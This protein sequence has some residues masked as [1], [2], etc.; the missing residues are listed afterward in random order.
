MESKS[1]KFVFNEYGS[2]REI[3]VHARGIGVLS[4]NYINKGTAFSEK[5]RHELGMEGSLP[6]TVRPLEKQVKNSLEKIFKNTSKQ[7]Q[8]FL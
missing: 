1:Y 5:E 8:H 2:T 3:K 4:N 7:C 6:P